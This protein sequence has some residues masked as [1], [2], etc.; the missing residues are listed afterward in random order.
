[1][2]KLARKLTL[3]PALALSLSSLFWSGN[4]IVGRA[5]REE[6]DPLTLNYWRWVIAL[7]ILLPFSLPVLWQH[8]S[9]IRQYWKFI[10]MLA[11]TGIVGFHF[12]VY[13]ALQTT[14][15]INALLF[16]SISPLM[17]IVGSRLAYK[18]RINSWQLM[19]I[20]LSL[21]GVVGLL[22]HG[23]PQR[24]RNLQFNSGDLWMLVAVVLWSVY[25]VILKRKPQQ[26]SQTVLLNSTIIFGVIIMTPLYFSSMVEGTEF[27]LTAL[28]I[29]GLLYISIFAAIV[30]YFCWNYG[31]S[32]IG[33][34]SAGS[35]LHLMPLFGAVLSVIF[36]GER[37][38]AYHLLGAAFIAAGIGISS[39]IRAQVE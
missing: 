5:L 12:C 2:S 19:G 23:D 3:S 13:R 35:F 26:L 17:I 30:A 7:L 21:A 28:N 27:E 25:S 4:F 11:I 20:L 39:R 22:T 1:M 38:M 6:V 31:V 9:T 33:P 24:L 14:Y 10:I 37:I 16:L 15:A 8:V 34:N 29:G 18:D 32:R 36:L